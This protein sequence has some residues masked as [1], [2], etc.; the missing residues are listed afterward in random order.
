MGGMRD[1][2]KYISVKLQIKDEDKGTEDE[3]EVDSQ[4]SMETEEFCERIA[5]RIKKFIEEMTL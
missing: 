5:R 3:Y 1:M 2:K 4:W